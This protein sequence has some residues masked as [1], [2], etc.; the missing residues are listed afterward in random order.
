MRLIEYRRKSSAG[1]GITRIQR[2]GSIALESRKAKTLASDVTSQVT[3][4]VQR[5]VSGVM[6]EISTLML[7]CPRDFINDIAYREI[8]SAILLEFS[9]RA[10]V[11]LCAEWDVADIAAVLDKIIGQVGFPAER[12]TRVTLYSGEVTPFA[13][14]ICVCLERSQSSG[15]GTFFF[16]EPT[17]FFRLDDR[18]ICDAVADTITQTVLLSHLRFHGGNMLCSDTDILIGSDHFQENQ[19]TTEGLS[20]AQIT[21]STLQTFRNSLDETRDAMQLRC[22]DTSV[23]EPVNLPEDGELTFHYLDEQAVG[24]SQPLFHIDMFVTP[25][26]KLNGRQMVVV[27]EPEASPQWGGQ[28]DL[29]SS[30]PF[31]EIVDEFVRQDY[32]VARIPITTKTLGMRPWRQRVRWLSDRNPNHRR[33][34]DAAM[35]AG[36]GMNEFIGIREHHIL[37]WNNVMVEN[38]G[39]DSLKILMPTYGHTFDNRCRGV[40]EKLGARVQDIP[41]MTVLATLRGAVHCVVRD[42]ARRGGTEFPAPTGIA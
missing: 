2:Y 10:A 21:V 6:G 33:I 32:L 28:I 27:A 29:L 14:D 36:A 8:L 30:L 16:L 22:E 41:D 1:R 4:D 7:V 18:N 31:Q 12:I 5:M 17:E 26:G 19:P 35:K 38:I 34:R 3:G 40:Y 20:A 25:L 24:R 39:W 42:V 37:S 11:I 15:T 13:Q 23:P 9:N